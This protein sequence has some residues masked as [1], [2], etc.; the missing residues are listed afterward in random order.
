[1]K[2]T[3]PVFR[4]GEHIPKMFT[5]LGANINPPLQFEEVPHK[6]QSLVLI[7]EDVDAT[8]KAWTHWMLFNI[9]ATTTS[10]NEG[11]IPA[12]ATEGL[13]NNRSFGYE[14]PC[15]KYFKGTHHYWFRLYALNTKLDLPASTEREEVEEK[16]KGHIIEK[17]ELPGLCT[18]PE[19]Q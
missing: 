18:A 1:M 13:A 6:A 4:H 19:E 14:G 16:M 17:A 7:F 3:S 11:T 12:D 9:A 5:C 10:I 15:P 2:I 8:P